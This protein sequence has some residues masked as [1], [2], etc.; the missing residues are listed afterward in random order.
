MQFFFSSHRKLRYL[1]RVILSECGILL[2]RKLRF[3]RGVILSDRRESNPKGARSAVSWIFDNH[4]VLRV[5]ILTHSYIF[6]VH[7][8]EKGGAC[9]IAKLA[10]LIKSKIPTYGRPTGSI[11]RL[12]RSKMATDIGQKIKKLNDRLHNA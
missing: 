11:P 5:A 2:H 1:P 6:F 9:A 12:H 4:Q 7:T 10:T 8:H 3:Y